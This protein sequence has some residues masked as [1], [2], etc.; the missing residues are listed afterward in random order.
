MTWIRTHSPATAPPEVK[1]AFAAGM[2]MYPADYAQSSQSA[3]PPEGRI[4]A[5]HSQIP[6][7]LEHAFATFGHAMDPSLPLSRKEHEMIATLVS[8]LNKCRY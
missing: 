1:A 5:S 6:A 4:V 3:I 2:G 7:V 8:T